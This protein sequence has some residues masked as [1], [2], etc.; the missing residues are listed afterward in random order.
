MENYKYDNLRS[1]I[2]LLIEGMDYL[3]KESIKKLLI[4][5]VNE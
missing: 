3:D 1:A 5:W 2:S 4:K